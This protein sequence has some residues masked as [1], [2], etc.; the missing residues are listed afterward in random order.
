MLDHLVLVSEEVAAQ[1]DV[2]GTV[3]EAISR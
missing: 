1:R 3:L 2:L